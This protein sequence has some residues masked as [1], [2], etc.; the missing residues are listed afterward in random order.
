MGTRSTR[1]PSELGV[2]ARRSPQDGRRS[3]RRPTPAVYRHLLRRRNALTLHVE[4]E[5]A[6]TASV[7]DHAV[8]VTDI[9]PTHAEADAIVAR[10]ER[11]HTPA[12]I[13]A[14]VARW[15]QSI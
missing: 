1:S 5:L 15:A 11:E 7:Y 8:E 4:V 12:E 6:Q 3:I 14:E 10:L 9:V 2:A 13:E